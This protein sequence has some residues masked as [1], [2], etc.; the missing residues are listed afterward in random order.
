MSR[1]VVKLSATAVSAFK[2]C[3]MRYY[4]RYV[5]GLT[6]AEEKASLR[7]GSAWHKVLELLSLR[8]GDVCPECAKTQ[9][10][11]SCPVCRGTDTVPDDPMDAAVRVIDAIYAAKEGMDPEQAEIEKIQ[12]LYAATMYRHLYAEQVIPTLARE[13]KFSLPLIGN[14][15]RA[16]PGVTVDGVIDKIVSVGPVSVMEHKTTGSSV[17]SGSDYWN[18]LNLDTQISLYTWAANRLIA[19]DD[20]TTIGIDAD[21]VV[22]GVFYD[23]FHKPGIRPSELT[24]AESQAFVET[25]TYC[26]VAFEIGGLAESGC[27]VVNGIKPRIKDGKKPGAF[28]IRETAEMYGARLMQDI[29]ERPEFYFARREIPRTTADLERFERE[30][31]NIYYAI[32]NMEKDNTWFRNEQQCQA[33]FKCEFCS[34]CYNNVNVG[35]EVPEGFK[36]LYVKEKIDGDS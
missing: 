14:G 22:G 28:S 5:K 12:I 11:A 18:H 6:T 27:L 2:A 30:L 10:N 1:R 21:T 15:G 4:L 13:L 8:P 3:P 25:G 7:Y 23:V 33:T 31:L 26:G 35:D 19:D 36:S 9:K 34:L 29:A 16:L 17:D 20:L 32:R 24:Q